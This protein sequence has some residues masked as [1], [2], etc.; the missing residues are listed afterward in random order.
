MGDKRMG[1]RLASPGLSECLAETER[2]AGAKGRVSPSS[3]GA[4]AFPPNLIHD[5]QI[6]PRSA[7]DTRKMLV[8][9]SSKRRW[10]FPLYQ[11][12]EQATDT[13]FVGWQAPQGC[14]HCW[15]A[16]NHA[17]IRSQAGGQQGRRAKTAQE[18][19]N[20]SLQHRVSDEPRADLR[21]R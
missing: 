2:Q 1:T 17:T 3:I 12:V 5:N 14:L 7:L 21:E 6:S 8:D 4:R 11:V 20:S 18:D 15:Q 10:F 16:W 9:P 13:P 19:I